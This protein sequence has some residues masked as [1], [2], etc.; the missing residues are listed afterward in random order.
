MKIVD[1]VC[2]TVVTIWTVGGRLTQIYRESTSMEQQRAD[3]AKT[4]RFGAAFLGWASFVI[5]RETRSGAS[6]AGQFV[7]EA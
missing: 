5:W 4:V 1:R 2:D 7:S 6:W 3:W